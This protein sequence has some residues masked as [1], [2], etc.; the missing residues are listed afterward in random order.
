[1][2]KIVIIG[3][4]SYIATGLENHLKNCKTDKLYFNNWSEN[5]DL[6]QQADCVINFS[7]APDFSTRK[8]EPEDV[9]YV[10]IAKHLKKQMLCADGIYISK[11][12]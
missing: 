7:I 8:I 12:K 5:I 1:M 9:L 11:T 2:E 3:S 6:L 10:Q 4:D